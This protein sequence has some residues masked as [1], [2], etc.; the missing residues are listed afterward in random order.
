MNDIDIDKVST[1]SKEKSLLKRILR[2]VFDMLVFTVFVGG[3]V[4]FIRFFIVNPFIVVGQSMEPT[5]HQND[6]IVIDKVSP[7]FEQHLSR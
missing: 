4:L 5:F 7:K 6:F 2:D 1:A 3:L